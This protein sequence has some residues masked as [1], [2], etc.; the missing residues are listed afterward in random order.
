MYL[1]SWSFVCVLI[2]QLHPQL[3]AKLSDFFHFIILLVRYLFACHLKKVLA[4]KFCVHLYIA[5]LKSAFFLT[6][7][8]FWLCVAG[9]FAEKAGRASQNPIPQRHGQNSSTSHHELP[10]GQWM[11]R[12]HVNLCRAVIGLCACTCVSGCVAALAQG[13]EASQ[14]HVQCW[15]RMSKWE[16]CIHDKERMS[17]WEVCIAW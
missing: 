15:Q 7:C 9:L 6:L 5:Q 11:D 2:L 8:M 10:L 13:M 12:G 4:W 14:W 3:H 16:L 17:K 1:P